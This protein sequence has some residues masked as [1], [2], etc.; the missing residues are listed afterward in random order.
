MKLEINTSSQQQTQ[1]IQTDNS[2][3][4]IFQHNCNRST[5]AMQSCLES[6]REKKIDIVLF[7]ESW[8]GNNNITISHPAFTSIIPATTVRSRVI[9]FI[10]KNATKN[11]RCTNRADISADADLQAISV[12]AAGLQEFL[13]LNV[14]NEKSLQD[15]SN[16][17]TVE[18]TLSSIQAADRTLICED[19][20]A[21]HSWWNSSISEARNAE[22]T[23]H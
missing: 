22:A 11:L 16:M 23:I 17:Y 20:N 12:S 18:R 13:L 14:Y 6:A 2:R 21:H 9:T 1:H 10:S 5:N 19:F 15:D 7:Q 8:I 3:I 4:Q